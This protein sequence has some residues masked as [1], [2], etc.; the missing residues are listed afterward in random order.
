MNVRIDPNDPAGVC[1]EPQ[2]R[3]R[4]CHGAQEACGH[5]NRLAP[6]Y[7]G[8]LHPPTKKSQMDRIVKTILHPIGRFIFDNPA[9]LHFPL[10]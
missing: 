2:G 8:S 3:R 1:R 6:H 10:N 5:R 7:S 9:R 4:R